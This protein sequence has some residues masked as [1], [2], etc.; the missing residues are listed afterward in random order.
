MKLYF[1]HSSNSP[2]ALDEATQF[3]PA[4][5]TKSL[6]FRRPPITTRQKPPIIPLQISFV[7]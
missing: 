3:F 7:S 1:P 5:A 4:D 2:S 6:Q